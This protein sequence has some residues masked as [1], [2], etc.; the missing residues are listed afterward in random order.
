[1][2]GDAT[3][4]RREMVAIVR[5]FFSSLRSSSTGVGAQ[6]KKQLQNLYRTPTIQRDL[7]DLVILYF[8]L[9][10]AR[11]GCRMYVS[12]DSVCAS[13]AAREKEEVLWRWSTKK[14]TPPQM[15]NQCLSKEAHDPRTA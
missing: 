3:G 13:Q 8:C 10:F 15:T 4:L 11:C 7:N 5:F 9:N 6:R 14:S 1:M 2:K 12:V